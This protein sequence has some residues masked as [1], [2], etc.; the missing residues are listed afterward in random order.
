[1][2]VVIFDWGGVLMRTQT[3]RFRHAWDRRLGL[4]PGTIEQIVHGGVAWRAAQLGEISVT[5]Y[6]AKIGQQLR[7]SETE[8]DVLLRDFYAGDVIDRDLTA[9]IQQIRDRGVP[10]GLLSNFSLELL[11]IL[12]GAQLDDLFDQRVISAEIGAMKPDP[13]A[14]RAILMKLNAEPNQALFIDDM[15]ANVDAAHSLGMAAL[16]FTP[17][18]DVV[19]QVQSWLRRS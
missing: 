11:D 13:K 4:P 10:V 7:L 6:H 19:E 18:L 8:T 9:Y 1:M 16:Q 12:H 17:K 3:R 5:N 2:K 14:Y 15:Q